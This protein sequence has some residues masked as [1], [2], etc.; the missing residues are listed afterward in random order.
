MPLNFCVICCNIIIENEHNIR[1]EAK[2]VAKKLFDLPNVKNSPMDGDTK[3]SRNI[4]VPQYTPSEN[5]PYVS[6]LCNTSKYAELMAHIQ[7]ADIPD[8]VKHFLELGA[9][10]HIVFN[11][12]KIADFYAHSP[13]NIQRL[14]EESALVILDM[15]DAIANGYV[16]LSEKMS[17]LAEEARKNRGKE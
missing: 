3:Y 8:E 9:T 13:A 17:Q 5:K 2:I 14:M 16:K 10:R 4:K 15:D 1:K 7:S 6:E 12:A 11:Y